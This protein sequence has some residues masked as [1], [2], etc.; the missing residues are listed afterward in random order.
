[1]FFWSRKCKGLLLGGSRG[2]R[3][4]EEGR[5]LEQEIPEG[6]VVLAQYPSYS[7]YSVWDGQGRARLVTVGGEWECVYQL[8]K[9]SL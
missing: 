3:E 5:R 1:M 4:P 2:A 6:T 9:E 8:D 7:M